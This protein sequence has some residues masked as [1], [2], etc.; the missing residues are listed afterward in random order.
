MWN[1]FSS[2]TGH[3]HHRWEDAVE[4]AWLLRKALAT[5]SDDL[6]HTVERKNWLPQV[7]L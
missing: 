7:I 4:M 2:H 1:T 6:K 5:K 3:Q